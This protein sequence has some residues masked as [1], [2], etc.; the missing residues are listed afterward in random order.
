MLS[1]LITDR[2]R[3]RESIV[4]RI[5]LLLFVLGL[6]GCSI[7]TATSS[8]SFAAS[9]NTS[10]QPHHST[11]I[12]YLHLFQSG[13]DG[14]SPMADLIDVNGT[15]YGTTSGPCGTA[16][17]MS[18]AGVQKILHLFQGD[19]DG[20]H[21][22]GPLADVNGTLYGTTAEGGFGPCD[23]VGCGTIYTV[24]PS[25]GYSVLYSFVGGL[26]G[27]NPTSGLTYLNGTLYGTTSGGGA[28]GGGT[29]YQ[30][31]GSGHESVLYSFG[32]TN[33][34]SDPLAG[35]IAVNGVLYGTTAFGGKGEKAEG[36]VFSIT[37]KGVERV[38]HTFVRTRTRRSGMTPTAVLTNVNGVLYGTTRYGGVND[39]GTIFSI[40]FVKGSAK[41]ALVYTF[42][43]PGSSDG[44][45]PASDVAFANGEL[46]GTTIS[47]GTSNE[48][49]VYAVTPSGTESILY[50]FASGELQ[51]P[52]A[53]VTPI[54][55]TYYGTTYAGG[56]GYGGVYALTP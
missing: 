21:P 9:Q 34:G 17:A 18:T 38:L 26:D 43:Q 44:A 29:V 5:C 55:G 25:G 42:G 48:G 37:T 22:E 4:R 7:P 20:C 49:T 27:K 19:S 47:G 39:E 56:A 15:L 24:T 54:N 6:G 28:Y 3:R 51:A 8:R 53:G 23:G 45:E 33:D 52:Y 10:R 40:T 30:I 11:S 35:L 12:A 41:Y 1:R 16:F 31:D 2:Y 32:D 13:L 14:A 50:D 36:T 46:V